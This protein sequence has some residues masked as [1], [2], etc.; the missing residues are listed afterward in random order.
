MEELL[1]GHTIKTFNKGDVVEATFL[2]K[3][4]RNAFFDIGGKS[5][6]V[7]GDSYFDEAKTFIQKL[8][9]GEKVKATV[10]EPENKEGRILISLRNAALTSLW[11]RLQAAK[12]K[13]TV[14]E[15]TG[16]D[17]VGKG[18][19]VDVE[20]LVGFIPSSQF[21]K[22]TSKNL[23]ALI[24]KRFK[25]KVIDLDSEKGRV[26]LSEKLVSEEEELKL[27]QEALTKVK[28]GDIYE[29]KVTQI[30]SFGAFVEIKIENKTKG[31][32]IPI[33]GL[34]HVSELS[35]EKVEDPAD[36]LSEGEKV[37]VK[38]IGVEGG[39]LALSIK[40]SKEDPWQKAEKKYKTDSRVE[41]VVVRIS[42]FGVFVNLEPGI[43]GLIHITKIPPAT[44]L[45][46]GDKVSCYV[47][48]I[49][50]KER[51]ISLGLVLTAKP[52]GYK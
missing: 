3:D 27:I 22:K 5:D 8:K 31:R 25:V 1:K 52:V 16:R 28:I 41:G 17:I 46:L 7:L 37:K 6:A 40:Q 26:L 12:A 10:M 29:G 20:S 18:M 48:G 15:V 45:K 47:E 9:V 4:K 11:E 43:E 42:D 33:E 36:V 32:G 21:G 44:K 51:R 38:V 2:G 13:G 19:T 35:W 23:E 49:D 24:G 34:V 30:T 50:Q 14:I 39:K